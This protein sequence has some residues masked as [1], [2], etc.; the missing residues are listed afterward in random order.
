[1]A[2]EVIG[3]EDELGSIEAFLARVEEGPAALVLSGEAGIGKTVLWETG[4]EEA[5]EQF[6]RVLLHRSVEAEALLSFTGLSDLLAPVFQEVAPSLAELRRRALEVALL[7]AEPGKVAPDPRAI[8]LAVLDVLRMLAERQPVVL[9]LDDLQWLDPSS[10][11]VLQIALRRLRD[12]RVG[13]LATVRTAP[14]TAAP[15]ELD[16]AFTA[17]RLVRLPIGPLSLGALHHLLRERVDLDLTRPELGRVHEASAGNPF[18]A[19]ELGRELVRTGSRPTA[20]RALPVP[21]SLYELLGGRLARL[22]TD[23][24]DVVLF[25]AALARPTVELVVKAHGHRETVVEALDTAAREGVVELDDS[26]VRFAHPLLASI[27]YEQAPIWKRRAIHGALARAVA[28]LEERARHMALSVDGPDAVAASYLDAAAEQAGA[29]GATA[30]AAELSELAADLTPDEPSL[31]RARRLRAARSYRLA[32]DVR[33]EALL[34]ALLR[35]VP[36]GIERSDVLFELARVHKGETPRLIELCAEALAEGRSDDARSVRIL[37]YRSAMRL[38]QLDI[39]EGLVDARAALERAERVGDPRLLALAI[40]RVGHAEGWAAEL[41]PGLVERGAEIERGL[42]VSLEYLES[43]SVSLARALTGSGEVE[44]QRAI[45]EELGRKAAERGDEGTRIQIIWRLSLADWYAGRLQQALDNAAA[46]FEATEQTLDRH[47]HP[48]VGRIKALIET[49]VGDVDNARAGAVEG[50]RIS[51]EL[52]DL[53]NVFLCLGVLGRL[54]LALGDLEAAG[55]C[56][57]DF[58]GR[59]LSLGYNDPTAPF[60]ADAIET[61]VA[62][63]ELERARAYLEPYEVHAARTGRPWPVAAAARCRGL[64][65][66]AEGDTPAALEAFDTALAM[67]DG[68][69]YPLERGRTLLCLGTVRR[70]A[71]QRKAAREALEE[72]LAIFEELGARLWA[73]KARSELKRISGRRTSSDELTETEQRVAELAAEGHTNKEIAAELFMGVSTVEAHLS[74]I[75]RKLG[76][77]S[78]TELAGRIASGEDG[79]KL[80]DEGA[81]V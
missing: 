71:Q 70:Q 76:L 45:L 8:G 73:E 41:T 15:V 20:G 58:P 23:T 36:S 1:M 68:L 61:L 2:T 77:R 33:A 27:C 22:P 65:A 79:A 6:G 25:A 56:L 52:S 60:W 81:Q 50:L 5:E 29:R 63:G 18:F 75:Y 26:R 32:G 54:E 21:E 62:L 55:D 39:G 48:F 13:L 4:V 51:E 78:R 53:A 66:A 24:G 46:A 74:R 64:L 10:A 17:D 9:S 42:G 47:A 49:D 34:D 3:R 7:L 11:G 72:A 28:D 14:D 16:R 30:A 37:A 31:S 80:V 67:L 44:R 40:A 43:P 38:Y 57:R 69:P 59:A 19:L 35:D 12:E